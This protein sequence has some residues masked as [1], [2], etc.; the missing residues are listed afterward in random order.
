DLDGNGLPDRLE[1][2]A[3]SINEFAAFRVLI[4]TGAG[5]HGASD[6]GPWGDVARRYR[7]AFPSLTYTG[8]RWESR[9]TPPAI[10]TAFYA[11]NGWND[12]S[13]YAMCSVTPAER[14]AN[15]S[16]ELLGRGGGART[17]SLSRPPAGRVETRAG[18]GR[19]R[20]VGA[21]TSS[22]SRLYASNG[23]PSDGWVEPMPSVK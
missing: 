16:P 18:G 4:N 3:P 21:R 15:L 1:I 13:M 7:D 10:A 20:G 11:D 22:L 8:P 2:L 14:V 6:S 12:Q 17:S 5:F 23:A 9:E 19:G